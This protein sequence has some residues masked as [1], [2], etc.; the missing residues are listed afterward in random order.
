MVELVDPRVEAYLVVSC[1]W[2]EHGLG[3]FGAVSKPVNVLPLL[4]DSADVD[5]TTF[6]KIGGDVWSTH[7]DSDLMRC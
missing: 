3:E 6:N 4:T 1:R 5:S 7:P 2:F